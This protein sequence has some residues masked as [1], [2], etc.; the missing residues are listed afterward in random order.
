MENGNNLTAQEA[1]EQALLYAYPLLAFQK[2]YTSL[3][4]R[5]GV[6]NLGHAR[7]LATS[8]SRSTVKPNAD[9]IYS[10]AL[11]DI[12]NDDLQID[13]PALPA[14]QYA[15]FSFHD[16][17]GNNF[18]VVG[19][20]N[21]TEAQTLYLTHNAATHQA[22]EPH[23]K[24]I[25]SPTT[26]GLLMIRW[27]VRDDNLQTIH[28]LQNSTAVRPSP[29][30]A[31]AYYNDLRANPSLESIDRS[32]DTRSP[33]NGALRLLC[34]V[35]D[36]NTPGHLANATVQEALH[37]SAFCADNSTLPADDIEASDRNVR[38]KFM[39]AGQASLKEQNNGWSVI[40]PNLAGK[41]GDNYG[42]R[43][44]ISMTGYLMLQASAALYPSWSRSSNSTGPPLQGEILELGARE[45]YIYTFSSKPPLDKL[46]FWSL[47]VYDADG[48]LI[49][50]PRNVSS[51]GDRSD[52]TY[53]SGT[54][55]YG[56]TSSA[57]LD[58][59]FQLLVQPADVTPPANWTSNWLPAPSGG[60]R[61]T[62]LL[63]F[64][65]ATD[66]LQDGRWQF[67]VV[68]KQQCMVDSGD[69]AGL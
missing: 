55:V 53:S 3:A 22:H 14:T 56:P 8:Q 40:Q 58:G 30:Q 50:N 32:K 66:E 37:S 26:F 36:V 38:A 18:A 64:Y 43:A 65:N 2:E 62:A 17:Y 45:S 59:Q 28:F 67:P 47:T 33:A 12:S 60:G 42:L 35:G 23:G 21:L 15:L 49:D 25:S 9:T 41:F 31:Q 39:S 19:P 11:Y 5:I 20:G 4:P 57:E 54:L 10:T 6:N 16:L 51:I 24:R 63:R 29:R 46:G 69:C 13:I 68:S 44:Q 52:I 27:L 34:Q 7:Q 61:F 48:Y 1:T